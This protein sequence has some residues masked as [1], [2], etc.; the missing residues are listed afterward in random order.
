MTD[1]QRQFHE[2]PQFARFLI[3][4][5]VA[6]VVNWSSRFAWSLLFP[7][8]PA[9]IAAYATGM[10][11]AFVLFRQFV[12]VGSQ[13]DLG[14]QAQRFV[15]VNLAGMAATVA[16]SHLFAAWILPAAGVASNVEA[17]AHAIAIAAPAATAWFGHRLLT[18]R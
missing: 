11:V 8:A 9:V 18:F 16:L 14:L 17:L 10:L 12:F 2:L 5:G 1:L 13:L 4:G 6:A 7:F 15:A 3:C